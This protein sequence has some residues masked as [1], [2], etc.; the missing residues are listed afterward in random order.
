M[1]N[2]VI[3]QPRNFIS[4]HY[5]YYGY[6]FDEFSKYLNTKFNCLENRYFIKADRERCPVKLCYDLNNS[7]SLTTLM[8]E[9]EMIIENAVTNEIK[10]LSV[11]DDL[12]HC[13]LDLQ[14]APETTKILISQFDRNK[15][16]AHVPN[17]ENRKKYSPWIYFPSDVF[18]IEKWYNKRQEKSDFI[19]KF[20][21]R[22]TA[23]EGRPILKY[24]DPNLFEGGMSIGPQD[25][26]AEQLINYKMG[27]SVAGRGEFCYRD[28][29]YM[30]MGIPFIRFNYVSEMEPNLIPNFHYIGIDRPSDMVKDREGT[31]EHAKLVEQRFLQVKD[32]KEF[33]S[34]VAKNA[35]E[36]Y[37]TYLL[38]DK[39]VVHTY[40]ILELQAW[41]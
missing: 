41:E 2:V 35:R 28:I 32:D 21:F 38:M 26:Y 11:A 4:R 7:A 15:I 37:E 17:E 29:E 30:G 13:N 18:D 16:Y 31:A 34:F 9:C 24:F 39:S 19:D 25:L 10:V 23:L 1:T 40:N 3:H 6:F 5:R 14:H 33:L 8:L 27:F 36:Y 22:G 20:Y 12:T